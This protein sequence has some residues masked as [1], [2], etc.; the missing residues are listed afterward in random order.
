MHNENITDGSVQKSAAFVPLCAD[1]VTQ[2]VQP[3]VPKG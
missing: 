1:W 3:L 2:C